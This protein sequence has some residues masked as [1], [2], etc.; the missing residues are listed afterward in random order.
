[1]EKKFTANSN[2]G[3]DVPL[4]KIEFDTPGLECLPL[5]NNVSHHEKLHFCAAHLRLMISVIAS[6]R[7]INTKLNSSEQ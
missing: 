7:C 4:D 3:D 6:W 5:V 1:M 2:H